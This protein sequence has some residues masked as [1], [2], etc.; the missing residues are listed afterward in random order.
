MM[1]YCSVSQVNLLQARWRSFLCESQSDVLRQS[2]GRYYRCFDLNCF[3]LSVIFLRRCQYELVRLW[4]FLIDYNY[5]KCTLFDGAGRLRRYFIGSACTIS[6]HHRV[7]F[8]GRTRST[9]RTKACRCRAAR[10]RS[11]W[12][13]AATRRA[14]RRTARASTAASPTCRR[15][16]LWRHA[17]PARA[18]W[19]WPSRGPQRPR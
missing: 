1:G 17:V 7:C 13:R 3:F 2:S 4:L 8:Q 10:S 12:C 14:S 9:S 11:T 16:S 6:C 19:A 5:S 15:C 18:A